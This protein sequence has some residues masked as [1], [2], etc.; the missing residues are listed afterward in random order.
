MKIY[1]LDREYEFKNDANEVEDILNTIYNESSKKGRHLAYAVI[2]GMDVYSNFRD[3][4]E[5]H[6]N[7][8]ESIKVVTMTFKEMI[9]NSIISI[10]DYIDEE[11]SYIPL[12][13]KRFESEPD[14]DSV[15]DLDELLEGI[16]WII[17]Y[18]QRVDSTQN[19]NHVIPDYYIWN[20]YAIDVYKLGE[21]IGELEEAISQ[22]DDTDLGELI[23]SLL[24]IFESM[25]DKLERL[26]SAKN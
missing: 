12:I 18:F 21:V 22:E 8:I 1:I 15:K 10:K 24:P 13:A 23:Y 3:Y 9:S 11:K 5:K 14:E 2:D 4:I 20:E 26:Y 7:S 16:G 19:L 25:A 6:I 17:E